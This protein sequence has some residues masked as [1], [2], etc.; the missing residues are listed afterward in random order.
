MAKRDYYEI[1]EV[2]KSA[3]VE[4]IKTAYRKKAMMYHPDRNPGNAEA[5]E[6]FKECAEAYEVLSDDNKR[7]RYDQFGHQGVSGPGGGAGFQDINDIFSHFGDIF[8]GFAG[9]RGGGGSIFDEFF[10][11]GSS[12]GRRRASRGIDGADLKVDLTLSLEEVAEGVTK[13]LKVKKYKECKVCNGSGAKSSSGFDKCPDCKGAG[14]VRH[15]TKSVFGQFINVSVCHRCN[16]E[17]RIIKDKC[18]SCRGE[19]RTMDE[20]TIKVN[21]PAGVSEGN[22]IPL[23]GQGHSGVRGGATG[24][25]YVYILEAKHKHF[26][27]NGD[28]VIFNLKLSIVDLIM[29]TEVI[30]PTLDGKAKVKIEGGTQ[31]GDMLK[32]RDKGI[33]RLNNYGRGDQLI[34]IHVNIPKKLTAKEKQLLKELAKTDNFQSKTDFTATAHE[35]KKEKSYFKSMFE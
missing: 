22:Y 3:S 13:T 35:A 25:L 20:S 21:I 23:R 12:S 6:M 8:G 29:G 1:L 19:G 4:E 30:V 2:S 14:E 27:R 31:I 16:G 28:D 24:D 18:S 26:V 11:G 32:L 34:K 9:G 7:R 15:V 33:K 10:G 17:G 5:E